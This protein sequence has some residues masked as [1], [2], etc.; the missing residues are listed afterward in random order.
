MRPDSRSWPSSCEP[1]RRCWDDAYLHK[2]LVK[3][4]D[5]W[6][7]TE[8]LEA[9]KAIAPLWMPCL[10]REEVDLMFEHPRLSCIKDELIELITFW[11]SAELVSLDCRW[12]FRDGELFFEADSWCLVTLPASAL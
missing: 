1:S 9:K 8:A 11:E 6:L 7:D 3:K 10:T 2:A 4:L 12:P 5:E